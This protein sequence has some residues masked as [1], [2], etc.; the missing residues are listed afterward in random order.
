MLKKI[1]IKKIITFCIAAVMFFTTLGILLSVVLKTHSDYYIYDPDKQGNFFSNL[2]GGSIQ[3]QDPNL[4]EDPNTEKVVK[5][6]FFL[7]D[8][9]AYQK[10]TWKSGKE[11]KTEAVPYVVSDKRIYFGIA[12]EDFA[13]L[14]NTDKSKL[15]SYSITRTE[16]KFY[17]HGE[18]EDG[19]R[20]TG[21]YSSESIVFG[22]D[23][24]SLIV[25]AIAIVSG[26][27]TFVTIG[28]II[29]KTL[30]IKSKENPE[31]YKKK[32][33]FT[34]KSLQSRVTKKSIIKFSVTSFLL[35]LTGL[36]LA[37]GI[38]SSH[39]STYTLSNKELPNGFVGENYRFE[40]TKE[41]VV[42]KYE[43]FDHLYITEPVKYLIK[44]GRYFEDM[45]L[46]DYRELLSE[47]KE[48]K[49]TKEE[50]KEFLEMFS[51]SITTK[52]LVMGIPGD[53]GEFKFK[54]TTGYILQYAGFG[55]LAIGALEFIVF[56]FLLSQKYVDIMIQSSDLVSARNVLS[57]Q[58][59]SNDENVSVTSEGSLEPS[60][61]N[62]TSVDEQITT[63]PKRP[64]FRK[65]KEE[66]K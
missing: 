27:T 29:G 41:G 63:K 11:E 60:A 55:L 39:T 49:L 62:E 5:I 42:E 14:S 32:Q 12:K 16:L 51:T 23:T 43:T 50:Q 37:T 36:I 19:N 30:L 58:T 57:S 18:D 64:K 56:L 26:F 4:E 40:F 59:D 6:E 47:M 17:T 46:S 28:L 48:D 66:N 15:E 35:I 9:M 1:G 20:N 54:S 45:T 33:R 22:L 38:Y 61:P 24:K 21:S 25:F 44:D 31:K 10:T 53:R 34:L 7:E 8:G 3:F 13:A 2:F 65:K 52:D